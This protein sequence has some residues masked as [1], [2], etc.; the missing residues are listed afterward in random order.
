[1]PITNSCFLDWSEKL[2]SSGSLTEPDHRSIVSRAYYSAYHESLD[3][4]DNTLELGVSQMIGG[5]HIKLSE[6]LTNYI[7]EDKVLQGT[8]RRIGTRLHLMH[9]LR[10]RADY[11]LEQSITAG[12]ANSAVKTV[13]SVLS[14][15]ANDIKKNAA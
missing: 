4:A 7:C 11:F 9:S 10:V 14:V 13:R 1:M 12:E 3:L 8:V 15:I 2:L 5:S 6:S